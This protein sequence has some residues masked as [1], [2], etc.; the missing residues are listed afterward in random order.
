MLRKSLSVNEINHQKTKVIIGLIRH[1]YLF[2]NHKTLIH[3]IEK[4]NGF[5]NTVNPLS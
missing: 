2:N 1:S 3:T 5:S 4:K